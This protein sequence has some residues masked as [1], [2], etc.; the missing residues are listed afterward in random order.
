MI[1]MR[2]YV[3]LT[4]ERELQY[5]QKVDVTVRAGGPGMGSGM[6]DSNSLAQTA[7]LQWSEWRAVPTTVERDMQC[8]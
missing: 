1:E 3:P 5:R 4:G 8:P 7:N 2:W 6:W